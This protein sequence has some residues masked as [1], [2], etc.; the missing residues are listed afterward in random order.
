MIVSGIK[1]ATK[2][3][4]SNLLP[5]AVKKLPEQYLPQTFYRSNESKVGIFVGGGEMFSTDE[6]EL[7]PLYLF[8][9]KLLEKFYPAL[10]CRAISYNNFLDVDY[11][12]G[13]LAF[14]PNESLENIL[15]DL[16]ASNKPFEALKKISLGLLD[17]FNSLAEA[18]DK[19]NRKELNDAKLLFAQLEKFFLAN[20][21]YNAVIEQEQ[22]SNY[23]DRLK[24]RLAHLHSAF[25]KSS[26]SIQNRLNE[27]SLKH[28]QKNFY[29]VLQSV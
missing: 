6:N 12:D 18:R 20:N 7:A 26:Q 17:E 1:K 3:K 10:T 9:F 28:Y 22:R 24:Y 14:K 8:R 4:F 15:E 23:S 27:L 5:N 11:H 2:D 13:K 25:S 19:S 29:E 21:E 16:N